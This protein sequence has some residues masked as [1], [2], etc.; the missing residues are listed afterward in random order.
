[1]DAGDA[2]VT[3][4]ADGN[5]DGVQRVTAESVVWSSSLIASSSGEEGRLEELGRKW[6]PVVVQ[7]VV[8]LHG[9][10]GERIREVRTGEGNLGRPKGG[11]VCTRWRRN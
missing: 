10:I 3:L 8:S 1:V 5:E 6:T 7:A 9:K 2:A 11:D 4:G